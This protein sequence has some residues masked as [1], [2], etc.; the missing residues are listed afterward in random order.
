M[1]KSETAKEKNYVKHF[2]V[3]YKGTTFLANTKS[4]KYITGY[5]KEVKKN[6][7]IDIDTLK[8]VLN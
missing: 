3:K 8:W 6:A 1:V 4:Q 5:L 2:D 7:L